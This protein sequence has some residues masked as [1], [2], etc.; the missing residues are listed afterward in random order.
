MSSQGATAA[1]L[2]TLRSFDKFSML[3]DIVYWHKINVFGMWME[4]SFQYC[5]SHQIFT[6]A[7]HNP[8][9]EPT[10]DKLEA[11]SEQIFLFDE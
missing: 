10:I 4:T 2:R 7:V 11:F 1:D 9:S 3:A 5:F 8:L 6:D